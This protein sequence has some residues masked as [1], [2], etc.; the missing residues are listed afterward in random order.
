MNLWSIYSAIFRLCLIKS[1]RPEGKFQDP[2]LS[3]QN[4]FVGNNRPSY[5]EMQARDRAW[6]FTLWLPSTQ[7]SAWY[8]GN[9]C[10]IDICWVNGW[11]PCPKAL[12]RAST[13]LKKPPQVSW[14]ENLESLLTKPS[15][16]L[17][18]FGQALQRIFCHFKSMKFPSQI[19]F[20]TSFQMQETIPPSFI[21]S[22]QQK[23]V[24]KLPRR[25]KITLILHS[26]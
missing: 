14:R 10:S 21:G 1:K 19:S 4:S 20:W 16:L 3:S 13:L 24:N 2:V 8:H 23:G 12:L 18:L 22:T 25:K 6:D 7:H 26:R 11:Q 5:L 15:F 9:W 17:L